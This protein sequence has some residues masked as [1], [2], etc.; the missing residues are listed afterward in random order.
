MDENVY[1]NS[2]LAYLPN[3]SDPW[4]IDQYRQSSIIICSGQGGWEG[5]M[6]EDAYAMIHLLEQKGIPGWVDIWGYDVNHDW[7]WWRKMMPYFLSK[8]EL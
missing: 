3:L 5:P 6:L 4:Y 2:P 8:L 1:L 7:P